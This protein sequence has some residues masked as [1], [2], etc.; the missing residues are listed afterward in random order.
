MMQDVHVPLTRT[1]GATYRRTG[2]EDP[3][4]RRLRVRVVVLLQSAVPWF[5]STSSAPYYAMCTVPVV[6]VT[7]HNQRTGRVSVRVRVQ[8]ILTVSVPRGI[9]AQTVP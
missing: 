3:G 7:T 5:I 4:P 1:S 8:H 6:Y 9:A 2:N